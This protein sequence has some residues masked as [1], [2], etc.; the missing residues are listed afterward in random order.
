MRIAY[1]MNPNDPRVLA[2]YGEILV[3]NNKTKLGIELLKKTLELDAIPAGQKIQITD[4]E[5]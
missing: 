4:I 5:I 3:R 2:V 1:S